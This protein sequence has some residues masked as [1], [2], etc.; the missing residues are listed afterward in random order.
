VRGEF[1]GSKSII[2]GWRIGNVVQV[3]TLAPMHSRRMRPH[4]AGFGL[5][6]ARRL[7]ALAE[8]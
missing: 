8:R 2:Y 1:F 7:E 3:A 4:P 5:R 6:L